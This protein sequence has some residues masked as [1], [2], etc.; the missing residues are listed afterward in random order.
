MLGKSMKKMKKRIDNIYDKYITFTNLYNTW[1]I[2]KKTC[3]NKSDIYK[4]SINE[5]INIY[6]IY[7][8]LKN[9]TY[10]PSKYRVFMIFEP[11]PRLVM[12]QSIAD[13]IVN[14][15]VAKYY[16]LTYLENKLIDSNV[17]TRKDKGSNYANKL[18]ID[19]I[20][21]MRISNKEIYCLKLD[22][23]KYFYNINHNILL[24]ML[25]KDIKDKEVLKLIE[26]I[27]K[28]TNNRYINE[29]IKSFNQRF[30]T[31]VPY[32]KKEV[33]L[34]IGAMTSQFLA[35][36]YLNDIDHYIKEV[37][38]CKYY[39]RYMD[40]F[41]ILDTNKK[42]L[43]D[44]WNI[45]KR[46]LKELKLKINPKSEIV[47]LSNG[48]SFLGYKYIS[49]KK[50]TMKYRKN[51]FYNIK[52]KLIY[53][54][55]HDKKLFYK[56]YASYYGYLSKIN[57]SLERKFKMKLKERFNY[58]KRKYPKSIVLLKKGAFYKT[59]AEDA[60]IL[61]YLFDYQEKEN[62]VGFGISAHAKVLKLLTQYGFSVCFISEEEQ[63]ITSSNSDKIYDLYLELSKI[64][65]QNK[66]KKEHLVHLFEE[67]ILNYPEKYEVLENRLIGIKREN[68]N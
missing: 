64:N 27:L 3:K 20:N 44:I 26:L 48:L 1:L 63:I 55:K 39:I 38:H 61:S 60:L 36:Y 10:K 50:L 43:K 6:N 25:K 2:V 12:S 9:R 58:Y 17:A 13:K 15:F 59:F 35:I 14:H 66:E 56:T 19:Y 11:K 37:L 22:I 28:Q 49:N 23:S 65:K 42:R 18:L 4:F 31:N 68:F 24:T 51:T 41:I 5:N 47:S 32:Y 29:Y 52:K 34:S 45:L 57:C 67:I 7:T 16:L 53:L 54:D 8:L 33:G 46:K 62:K 30:N 21:K 40:D